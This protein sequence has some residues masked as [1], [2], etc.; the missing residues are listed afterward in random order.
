MIDALIRWSLHN[1]LIVLTLAANIATLVG[2][3]G[4]DLPDRTTARDPT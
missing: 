2:S 1:K 3:G 4:A